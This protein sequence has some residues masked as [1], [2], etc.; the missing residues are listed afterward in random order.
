[1][2]AIADHSEYIASET[3]RI[4]R[5]DYLAKF[6]YCADCGIPRRM[7]IVVYGE[8]LHVHHISYARIG[9]ELDSDLQSLC[10]RDHQIKSFGV[11]SLKD[12]HFPWNNLAGLFLI[13]GEIYKSEITGEYL[14][15]VLVTKEWN[16]SSQELNLALA[17][18]VRTRNRMPSPKELLCAVERVRHH[19]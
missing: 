13:L 4:R 1:V 14:D 19:E 8:D 3:W 10:K 5:A 18:I 7:S 2:G 16:L 17:E 11:S 15:Q 6:P 12:W 9:E